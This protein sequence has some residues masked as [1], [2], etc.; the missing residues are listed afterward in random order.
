MHKVKHNSGCG[1]LLINLTYAV[2]K[3]QT[4]ILSVSVRLLSVVL[5]LLWASS[6]SKVSV[7][8]PP[9]SKEVFLKSSYTIYSNVQWSFSPWL[10]VN[11]LLSVYNALL[12]I[13]GI[14]LIMHVLLYVCV[15]LCKHVCIGVLQCTGIQ[16]LYSHWNW[17]AAFTSV[18]Y[19]PTLNWMYVLWRASQYSIQC[20]QD[21]SRVFLKNWHWRVEEGVGTRLHIWSV[22]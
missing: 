18:F 7:G 21:G 1:A 11:S 14:Q 22:W 17:A 20:P 16:P 19:W 13:D 10:N 3:F 12:T 4:L 2:S 8:C 15:Q 5:S 9:R 6:S